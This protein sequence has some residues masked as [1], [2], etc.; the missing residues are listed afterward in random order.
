MKI[1]GIYYWQVLP[2]KA[3]K[4]AIGSQRKDVTGVGA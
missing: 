2:E 1:K 3:G 4:D